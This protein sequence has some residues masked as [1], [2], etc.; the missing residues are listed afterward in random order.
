MSLKFPRDF[1]KLKKCV[2]RTG[3]SGKWRELENRQMQYRT[4]DGAILNWS[5]KTGTVWFQGQ[6]PAIPE[7]KRAFV[8]VAIKKGLLKGEYDADD[9]N[10]DLRGVISEIAKLKRGQKRMRIDIV[11][12][13]ET[14]ARI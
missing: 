2:S 5:K 12:L 11:E 7:F 4:D 10:T 9:K 14:V 3:V 13:K 1:R 8:K 6:K